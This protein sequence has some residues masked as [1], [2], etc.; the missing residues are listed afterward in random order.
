MMDIWLLKMP[1]DQEN[2]TGRLFL[3]WLLKCPCAGKTQ[4]SSPGVLMRVFSRIV[5]YVG[6]QC[7]RYFLDFTTKPWLPYSRTPHNTVL[8][9]VSQ[10][11]LYSSRGD[12]HLT[13]QKERAK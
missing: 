12:I 3:R 1:G 6:A 11:C 2:R 5:A 13:T 10:D 4:L 8:T 9:K 7:V